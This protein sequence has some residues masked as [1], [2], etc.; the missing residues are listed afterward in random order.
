[1]VH[2]NL[3]DVLARGGLTKDGEAFVVPNGLSVT[4]YLELGHESLIVD[5]VQRIE[6]GPEVAAI[7]THRKER[8]AFELDAFSAVRFHPEGSGAGYA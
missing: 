2:K 4:V 7:V 5:R 6:V 1:M 3:L 8:Y